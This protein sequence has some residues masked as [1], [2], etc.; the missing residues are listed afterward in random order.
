MDVVDK[1]LG[2]MHIGVDI[3]VQSLLTEVLSASKA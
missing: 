1:A 2:V 3:S